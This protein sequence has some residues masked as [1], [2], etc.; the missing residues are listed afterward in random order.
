MFDFKERDSKMWNDSL[1]NQNQEFE[2]KTRKIEKKLKE[3]NFRQK[4]F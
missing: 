3:L 2:R 1:E 4:Q